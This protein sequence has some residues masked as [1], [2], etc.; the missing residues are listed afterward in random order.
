MLGAI[1][2]FGPLIM[3]GA[4]VVAVGSAAFWLA[5]QVQAAA[6]LGNELKHAQQTNE[7]MAAQVLQLHDQVADLSNIITERLRQDKEIDE[8]FSEIIA[9][10]ATQQH[11]C[12]AELLPDSYV[13]QLRRG[14]RQANAGGVPNGA[15]GADR[16][17]EGDSGGTEDVR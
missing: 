3:R 12:D 10:A 4:M 6:S 13:E 14:A 17:D 1:L 2:R 5:S 8:Q 11:R 16:A 15:P 9:A 7:Q